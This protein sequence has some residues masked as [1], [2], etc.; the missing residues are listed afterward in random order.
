MNELQ[1]PDIA[2]ALGALA[3]DDAEALRKQAVPLL[4]THM[5]F[6]RAEIERRFLADNDGL[7]CCRGLSLLID[8]IVGALFD[9]ADRR[10]FAAAN[11]T[12]GERVALAAIGGYG[13]GAL[14]PYSDIDLLALVPYKRTA[15]AER[16]VEF[17]LYAL[18]DLGLKVGQAVRAP[19]ECVRLAK[20]DVLIR[21]SM[22]E[23]RFLAGDSALYADL[24]RRFVKGVESFD[25]RGFVEAKLA[26]RDQR[27]R[28]AGDSRYMVEPNIKDGKGGQRDLQTLSWIARALHGV[29]DIAAM[30]P[31][32]LLREEEASKFA[33]AEAFLWTVRC[34][35]HF[36]TRRA[37]ERLTFDVQIEIAKRLG[38][39]DH[40]GARAVERFMKHYFLVAKDVGALT[41]I[42][43]AAFEADA[44]GQPRSFL[45]RASR[46]TLDG[47]ILEGT[48]LNIAMPDQFAA[49]P[50]DMI[51]LFATAQRGGFDIHPNALRALTRNLRRIG[52]ELRADPEANRLFLDGILTG[53][54]NREASMR[55][56]NDAGV[57]G[58]FIPDF[59]RIVAQMQFDMY[60][61][62][63]VDEHTLNAIGILNR[64]E[65]GEAADKYK[66][67]A[68]L[69]GRIA[70]RR[71]LSLAVLVHDIGKGRGGNHSEIGCAI[72]ERLGPRLGLTAE[73][74]E[75]AAWLVRWHLAMSGVITR[76]DIEDSR[77]V[78]DFA[79][80]VQSPERLK[81]LTVLTTVDISAVGPG[82][83][84]NW[85][86]GLLEDLYNRT[87]ET[88][89]GAVVSVS[90]AER[91][92][93]I[94]AEVRLQLPE[95]DDGQFERYAALGPRAY[96]L[97]FDSATQ[98]RQARLING[99]ERDR[100]ALAIETRGDPQRDAT[101]VTIHTAD[102]AGLFARLAGAFALCGL[103]IV[104]AKIFT[105][106]NGMALDVFWAQDISGE[107]L[108]GA[109]RARLIVTI[110]RFLAGGPP[111]P[112]EIAR[113]TGKP[114]ERARPFHV[115]PRALIDNEASSTHTII[116]ING[117]DRP[118]LLYDVTLALTGLSVQIASAKISTYGHKVIDVFYVKDVFGLKIIDP[119][120]QQRIR[121]ALLEAIEGDGSRDRKDARKKQ[122]AA[123]ATA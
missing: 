32:G 12:T 94:Q 72:A 85:K 80:L 34:H 65:T 66:L 49:R 87:A 118:G 16:I 75:T 98:A 42:F 117:C 92:S 5:E 108:T 35:L 3:A 95:W 64:I 15:R 38:Y 74:T 93:R 18:W 77:T 4:K 88:L 121:A 50:T 57:L 73:E 14:A 113:L 40:V 20:A 86:A 52:S 109:K 111:R 9:L 48:R 43:C 68:G 83:W 122:A 39:T 44:L 41:R 8:G 99:A 23:R 102:H 13:R 19:E 45:S 123:G 104:D 6:G 67:A 26:E 22:M 115:T 97:A 2:A 10:V 1:S 105:L 36:L 60:H 51:R 112:D 78:Q 89:A 114:P 103:S 46:N 56:M 84:N 61:F 31:T 82:R 63:T 30:A 62:Y 119:A 96:W 24:D 106:A 101:E 47:F 54:G 28:R 120:Q 69:I 59:G 17:M 81:A 7:A 100:Q 90:G 29:G 79:A 107:P 91:V 33:K 53:P 76:R 55:R 27:H 70:S 116:E 71:A 25:R 11:P 58:R 37:E 110:E 21:T